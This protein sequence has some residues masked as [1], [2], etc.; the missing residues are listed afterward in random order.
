MAND[1]EDLL[2]QALRLPQGARATLAGKLLASL[3]DGFDTDSEEAW[4][5]E[6]RRR[7]KS[8]AD[9]TAKTVSWEE[10]ERGLLLKVNEKEDA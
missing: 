4:R 7:V 2:A 1:S 10:V 6:I 8:L 5:D 3:D 9:G